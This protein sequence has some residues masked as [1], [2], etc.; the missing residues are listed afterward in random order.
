MEKC[1]DCYWWLSHPYFKGHGWCDLAEHGFKIS[2]DSEI[3]ENFLDKYNMI[4]T[5]KA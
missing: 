3:C 5:K 2:E 4:K 1:K